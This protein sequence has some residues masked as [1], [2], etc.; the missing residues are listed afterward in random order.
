VVHVPYFYIEQ[1]AESTFAFLRFFFLTLLIGS[2]INSNNLLSGRSAVRSTARLY[3]AD[4]ATLRLTFISWPCDR[5]FHPSGLGR[6]NASESTSKE[7]L[8]SSSFVDLNIFLMQFLLHSGYC[9]TR[10]QLPRHT[11]RFTNVSFYSLLIY[12]NSIRNQN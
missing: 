1:E 11:W 8:T 7:S 5:F 4:A 3:R 2:F 12:A 9:R 10:A 6:G